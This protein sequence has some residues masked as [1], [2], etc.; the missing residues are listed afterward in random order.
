MVTVNAMT[1]A[2]GVLARFEFL[3]GFDDEVA[4]FF[5]EGRTIVEGQPETTCWY[6]FRIS[7]T[8]YGAFAA[9]ASAADR[10]ALLASGGPKLS[11][12]AT[13][14]FMARRH[15]TRSTSWN[16]ARRD[17]ELQVPVRPTS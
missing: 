16:R 4:C 15:L 9:F 3:P 17:S 12:S 11:A 8:T 10:D 13:N 5:A 7:A 1:A 14:L 6:A 2:V